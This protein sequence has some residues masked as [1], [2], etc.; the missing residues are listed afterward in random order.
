VAARLP[1]GAHGGGATLTAFGQKLVE[2]YRAIEADVLAATRKR[3]RDIG[4]ALKGKS[5]RPLTSLRRTVRG[6]APR[7][8]QT[9][10][11]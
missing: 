3:L 5:T 11:V 4:M 7:R 8:G 6:M 10:R 1:G 2:R 9:Q